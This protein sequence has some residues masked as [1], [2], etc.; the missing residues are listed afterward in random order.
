MSDDILISFI[1]PVYN[2]E[3]TISKCL[4]SIIKQT[5]KNFEIIVVNDGTRDNAQILID[6]YYKKYPEIIKAFIKENGGLSDARNYGIKK[7]KG[8]YI[9]FVDS[10]DYIENNYCEI[11]SEII[12]KHKTDMIIINYNRIYNKHQNYFERNYNF[13]RGNIYN[14]TIKINENPEIIANTE[15]ASWLRILKREFFIQNESFYFTNDRVYEDL[16]ASL[17]WYLQIDTVFISNT[18]L[19]NYSIS[20]NTLNFNSKNIEMFLAIIDEICF[21]YRKEMKFEKYYYELEYL[22]TK[23]MLLSNIMRLREAKRKNNY[24]I[25]FDLRN[26]L[27]NQFNFFNQ[28]KYLKNEPF[29]VRI[30]VFI[31][32]Y[33]PQTLK[34]IL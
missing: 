27:K 16:E 13:N 32:Y 30:F 31:S 2:T 34:L 1:V 4:D 7:S 24:A 21:Y 12:N 5:I 33:F 10:D 11:V 14:K 6:N 20:K 25:F 29:Y 28:N 22:F 3:K 19:Y 15:V 9:A 18:R 26:K 23:H 17:K 8:K